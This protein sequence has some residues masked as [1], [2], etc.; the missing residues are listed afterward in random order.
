MADEKKSALEERRVLPQFLD[1]LMG[2][3]ALLINSAFETTQDG[4]VAPIVPDIQGLEAAIAVA[5][6]TVPDKLS[7]KEI[8]FLRKALGLRATALASFLDVTPET[9]SRW[10]NGKDVIST[11]AERILRLRVLHGLRARAPGV[12]AEA[13]DILDLKISPFRTS[14]AP[15]TLEFARVGALSQEGGFEQVWIFRGLVENEPQSV[16]LAANVA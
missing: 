8:R 12:K 6:V 11:N 3:R 7:N 14:T 16:L 2:V 5:R 13:S 15:T 10:E 4:D 9:F 1:K